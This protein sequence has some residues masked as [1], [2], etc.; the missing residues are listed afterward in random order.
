M[1]SKR[2]GYTVISNVMFTFDFLALADDVLL[3]ENLHFTA[4]QFA[5][6][7]NTICRNF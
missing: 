3:T 7:R 2:A 1:F 5:G 6:L 4:T